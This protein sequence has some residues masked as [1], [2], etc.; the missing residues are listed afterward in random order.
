MFVYF[1]LSLQVDFFNNLENT[2]VCHPRLGLWPLSP[3]SIYGM[4]YISFTVCF[5]LKVGKYNLSNI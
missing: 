5:I 2:S 4:H 1:H 3:A